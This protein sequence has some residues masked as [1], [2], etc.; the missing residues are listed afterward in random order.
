MG[1]SQQYS[2]AEYKVQALGDVAAIQQCGVHSTNITPKCTPQSV[3]ACDTFD[4]VC[5]PYG[6]VIEIL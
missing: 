3:H 1:M 6:N 5:A 2:S 4:V